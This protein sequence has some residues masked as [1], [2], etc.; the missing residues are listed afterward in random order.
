M[1]GKKVIELI[2]KGFEAYEKVVG[3]EIH[4]VFLKQGRYHEIIFKASKKNFMHLCGVK[5]QDPKTKRFFKA[6]EFYKAF[7]NKKLSPAGI[8]KKPDGTTEQK[9]Q[10]IQYLKDLTTCNVRVIDEK[11]TFLN[12]SFDKGIRSK[13]MIFCLALEQIADTFTPTSLLNLK[14]AKGQVLKSGHAIH[15][16]YSVDKTTRNVQILCKTSEFEQYESSYPY[17]TEPELV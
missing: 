7:K 8:I 11:T 3:K 2:T 10:I 9:L 1:D 6:N 16:I 12:L 4:Y 15:C 17:K 5:Y 13:R 14:S